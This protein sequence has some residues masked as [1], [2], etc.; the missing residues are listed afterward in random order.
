[1]DEVRVYGA[2]DDL[3]EVE[4]A[5]EEE[6][7][8]PPR[9]EAYLGFSDGTL[10]KIWYDSEGWGIRRVVAGTADV[11]IVNAYE[12]GGPNDYADIATLTGRVE[13]VVVGAERA[14]KG[15]QRP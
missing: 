2:S 14:V 7:P 15:F 8:L 3:I 6:F 9:E 10:L 11:S 4:G 1:M 13:W 5:I 12:H